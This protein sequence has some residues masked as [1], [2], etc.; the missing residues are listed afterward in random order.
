MNETCRII[1]NDNGQT[2]AVSSFE[3]TIEAKKI[4]GC[5]YHQSTSLTNP[6]SSASDESRINKG[7]TNNWE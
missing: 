3:N 4:C 1:Y 6:P 7:Y 5:S 2:G